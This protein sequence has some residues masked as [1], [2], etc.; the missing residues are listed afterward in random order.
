MVQ[1]TDKA[2]KIAICLNGLVIGQS[3]N[4]AWLQARQYLK[5][6]IINF[7]NNS[8]SD[9]HHT[10]YQVDVFAHTWENDNFDNDEFLEWYQPKSYVIEPQ[11]HFEEEVNQISVSHVEKVRYS[12][13]SWAYSRW[14]SVDLKQKYEKQHG[15]VYDV[16]LMCRYD[17][18]HRY[19]WHKPAF[20]FNPW[21]DMEYVYGEYWAGFNE[22]PGDIYFYSK[23]E[24]IDKIAN[25]YNRL[26]E[27]LK[28][29]SEYEKLLLNNWPYGSTSDPTSNEVFR[30]LYK[31]NAEPCQLPYTD[32][33]G[34]H[35]IM[36]WHMMNHNLYTKIRPLGKYYTKDK[37]E[38]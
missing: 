13:F 21:F 3:G 4:S 12:T 15:F 29:D 30:P 16:V 22:G 31:R 1:N 24:N 37:S 6:D 10:E 5:N 20:E 18:A 35:S 23:S 2:M 19:E 17:H 28:A 8:P 9:H 32:K 36:K 7:Y 38:Y 25:L 26:V 33:K 27:Y 34:N 14:K 11:R